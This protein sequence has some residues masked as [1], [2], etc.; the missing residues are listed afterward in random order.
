[1]KFKNLLFL[2]VNLLFAGS[3][4]AQEDI[5]VIDG[6][7]AKAGLLEATING[8]TL[9]GGVRKNPNRIYELKAN[10]VYIQRGPINV[11]NPTG[12]ITIRGQ[13]GGAKPVVIKQPLNDVAVGG[14]TINSNL[15]FLN[16]QYHHMETSGAIDWGMFTL[17]GDKRKL[18]V[19]DCL[20]ENCR[21]GFNLTSVKQGAVIIMRNNY[22]RDLHDF[23]Q[24][25]AGR[26]AECK[27][28]I[29]TLIIENNTFTGAGLLF[30]SQQSLTAYAVINHNT[31]VNNVKYPFL[32]QYWKELYFTN[33][34]FVNSNMAGEDME[35]V[36]TGGQDP[37]ALMHGI[38]GV[39]TVEIGIN[40]QAKY[41]NA[42]STALTEDV[43]QISDYKVYAA[44][45]VVVSSATLDNYYN[46]N[47]DTEFP[48]VAPASYLT[49]VGKTPPYKVVN[50]PGIWMNSR[51]EAL[52]AAYPNL[53]VVN[54][55]IYQFRTADLG[56]KTDPLPQAEADVFVLWNRKQWGVPGLTAPTVEETKIWQ[57]GDFDPKTVPGKDTEN[58][59]TTGISKF[60]DLLE[61]FSYTK[62]LVS[63]SDG[64]RIGS[65]MW[66]DETLDSQASLA[67]IKSAYD[68]ATGIKE[69]KS[70]FELKSYP[71]P[72]NTSTTISFKLPKQTRVNLSVYDISGRI[73]QTLIDENRAS[74]SY[75]SIFTPKNASIGTY[76]YKL[77]TDDAV[78]SGKMMFLK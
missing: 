70:E 19:E 32:N 29:D 72:F 11:K 34:L 60:S 13:K 4:F 58:S 71:N 23:S 76:F 1:M 16:I 57:F 3:L 31:I 48:G 7:A 6:G 63:K 26:A 22:F 49:W 45:N 12:T 33:N 54:N 77:T 27:Q 75:Q 17:T 61:D 18:V 68:K 28:P 67:A 59:K 37:D 66:N 56:L 35:N 8:D 14:S 53:K 74:G 73:V 51:T 43:D 78:V 64:L 65:L 62:S 44:D 30:L 50:V 2:F 38:F 52:I 9:V 40:L 25:W 55:S 39:D 10:G 69:I 5:L 36:A 15:T 46:G 47:V 21:I 42:D 24:W 41:M 20:I